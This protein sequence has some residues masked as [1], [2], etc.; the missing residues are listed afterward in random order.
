VTRAAPARPVRR[1]QGVYRRRRLAAA[2]TAVFLLVCTAF[3][4]RVALYDAHLLDVQGVQV[5]GVTT[6]AQADVLTAAAV[7]TGAP[8]ASID[9]AA[10]A[11]RV[12][13]LPAVA[14]AVVARSWPHTVTVTVVERVPVAVASTPAGVQLVDGGGVV[15]SGA[16]PPGLPRLTFG[17]VGPDDPSTRSALA[18]LATLPPAVR[19][20]VLT[21]DATVAGANVPGQV[22]FGLTGG[23]RVEWGTEDRAADKAAVLVPLL[24]QPGHVFDVTS[25]DLP[26]IR[27]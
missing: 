23:R 12:A 13:A 11:Q 17:A 5:E 25:P 26:T 24:T 4:V 2:L 19:S 15:Y 22:T 14:S 6:V 21:V 1:V 20:Q 3:V 7:P 18:A 8:L 9:T 16:A 10:V 27:R